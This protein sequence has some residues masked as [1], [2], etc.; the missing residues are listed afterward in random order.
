MSDL[1][2]A[3]AGP[4]GSRAR[5]RVLAVALVLT[6]AVILVAV[7]SPLPPSIGVSDFRAYWSASYLL[8]HGDNF[9]SPAALFR[10]EQD[11]TLW[12]GTF[13][14]ATWN[15]PWLLVLLEPYTFAPF[16]RAV[17]WWLLTNIALVL[18]A[19]VG[20]W[21]CSARSD[22]TRRLAYVAWLVAFGFS[23]TL[24]AL[25]AGQVSIIVFVS[26]ALFL[27]FHA[28]RRD[29]LAGASLALATVKP[30]LVY[31]LVPIALLDAAR[32]RRWNVLIGFA[33]VLAVSVALA[34]LQRPSFVG[35]YAAAMASGNLLGYASPTIG[36]WVAG[37]LGW[38]WARLMG[39]VIL[40]LAA[41]VWWHS[42]SRWR[43]RTVV[44]ATL[45]LSVVAAPFAWS[46]DFVVLLVPLLTVFAWIADGL[47]S[48]VESAA[49]VG[50][51]VAADLVSF[52]QRTLPLDEAYFV[53]LPLVV[54]IVYIFAANR[55]SRNA[56]SLA[57]NGAEL[58][59]GL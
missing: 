53:W 52:V 21:H 14:I 54:A 57:R 27:M 3:G 40:P 42:G 59:A 12:S 24:V 43:M 44:D 49:I 5:S 23:P 55:A 20:A 19:A 35:E 58:A 6:A 11:L 26:L 22:R 2:R 25:V 17:W 34:L 13:P 47:V 38:G 28:R 37:G 32:N 4:A 48:R 31:V 29:G 1:D 10:V 9:A 56:S 18:A 50:A 46:Y 41:L 51:L 45:L 39:I 30:Q 36:A 7:Q 16:S 15:P 33:G 8:Q